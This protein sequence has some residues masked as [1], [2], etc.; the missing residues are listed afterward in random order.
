MSWEGL[1]ETS[2]VRVSQPIFNSFVS[3]ST[4]IALFQVEMFLEHSSLVNW[5]AGI[6]GF[7]VI[8]LM[9][10]QGGFLAS[11]KPVDLEVGFDFAVD[12]SFSFHLILK[13]S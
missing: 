5:K 8:L 11:S 7:Q 13:I 12:V 6:Y 2:T 10:I 3:G 9:G 4:Y 1:L